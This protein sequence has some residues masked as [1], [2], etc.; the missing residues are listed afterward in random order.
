MHLYY[1][2]I[3]LLA[4]HYRYRG[5]VIATFVS[6]LYVGLVCFYDA[7]QADVI[8]GAWMRFFVFIG[9]AA[10]V[11]YL[12]ER[13]YEDRNALLE[14]E[15]KL[16]TLFEAMLEGF[17]YCRMIYDAEGK[18]VDW[19]YLEVNGAFGRLTGLEDITGKRV[20]EVIPDIRTLTPELF[21]TYGRVASTGKPETFEIDFKP[22][23]IWLKVSVFSPAKGEFIAVFEDITDFRR[24]EEEHLR[25]AAIVEFSDDAIIG[26]TLDGTITSWN[27]GARKLYGYTA[28]EVTG[29]PVSLLLPPGEY[30][31]IGEI[32]E[33]I[34]AGVTVS[35]LETKRRTKDGRIIDVSL[36]ISPIKDTERNVLGASTIARDI[37]GR[38]RAEEA[39]LESEKRYRDM[40]ELN[41]A[42]MFIVNPGTGR[43]VD[44]N[45]AASRYYGYSREELSGM[46]ITDINIADPE[47]TM[48]NMSHAAKNNGEIFYFRHR[49]KSGEIRDVEVF[50]A[51]ITLGDN[52]LLHSIVHDV[53]ERQRAE[54]AL[55]Q[56]NTKLNLLSS[57]T[58]HDIR[59]QIFA[60][61]AY[62]ELSRE[63]LSDTAKTSEYILKEERAV[64][65]M[66]RQITFTKEYQDLGVASPVWEN[67]EACVRNALAALPMRDIQ[68]AAEVSDLDVFADPLFERVFYNLIDNALRYG[69]QKMTA[70]R[71][72]AQESEKGLVISV[73]DNG[74]G[75]SSEDKKR[76]FE[77]GFGHHTG[78]GLFL[79]RE[80]L[81]ITGITITE[82][83]EPGTGARFEI[84]VPKGGYRSGVTGNR[85]G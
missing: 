79:S 59:N 64:N 84:L 78:L 3:I 75:I 57:I 67:V 50:S 40:F 6:L 28:E 15:R 47:I 31:D 85:Q 9:V 23:K 18:P 12:S 43:I 2:P 52:R 82:T 61:K 34:R 71:I 13:L 76:L 66:E 62:L 27:A 7:G 77:R 4:Y 72:T 8:T 16:R 14:S 24:T 21:D 49:K 54:E 53:T 38:K 45:S 20:R 42:V 41:N 17:A 39:L 19:V 11:A 68:V 37:T 69:G 30:D 33:K 32:L 5:F 80:I 63:T 81:A 10:V 58:R 51:P 55:K 29:R 44:A 73:E 46:A 35:H 65:A 36:T 56:A 83:G 48:K 22:L 70:I 25:L 26:K 74:E 1:F 60:L